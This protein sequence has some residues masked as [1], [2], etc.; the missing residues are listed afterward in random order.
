VSASDSVVKYVLTAVYRVVS[1]AD[2]A[3]LSFDSELSDKLKRFLGKI[4]SRADSL[5]RSLQ[6]LFEETKNLT[7]FK[8]RPKMTTC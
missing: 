5:P 2:D 7:E 6:I 1:F 8:L 4:E 3:T